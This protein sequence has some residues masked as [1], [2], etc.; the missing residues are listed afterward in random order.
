MIKKNETNI[1]KSKHPYLLLIMESVSIEI[2]T[3]LATLNCELKDKKSQIN[4]AAFSKTNHHHQP[5]LTS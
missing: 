5:K 1:R 3:T 2:N 4:Q